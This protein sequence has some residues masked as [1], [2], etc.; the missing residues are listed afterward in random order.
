MLQGLW[1]LAECKLNDRQAQRCGL[2]PRGFLWLHQ[3][4]YGADALRW[5]TVFLQTFA[6]N[7]H[8]KC[9]VTDTDLGAASPSL[10]LSENLTET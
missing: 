1:G 8:V 7:R 9:L 2:T 6:K 3:C 5:T 10:A 4:C